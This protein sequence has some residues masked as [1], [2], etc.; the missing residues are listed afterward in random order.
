MSLDLSTV[1]DPL[2]ITT[3]VLAF[4]EPALLQRLDPL[5]EAELDGL[6]FGV[7]GFDAQGTVRRYNTYESQAAG[8]SPSRVLG[9]ALFTAVAPCMNNYLVAQRFEDAADA[10]SELDAT[11]DYVL[12]L[13]MRPV[14]VQLRL[15]AAPRAGYRYVL[16]RRST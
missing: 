7:I 2:M 16:V 3:Q 6:D 9:Y 1:K 11:I 15:L 12:T 13:R 8:L 14:K 10:D 5:T 4:D